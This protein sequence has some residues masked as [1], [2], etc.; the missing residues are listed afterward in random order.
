MH[1][2]RL[3][4]RVLVLE[5]VPDL[6]VDCRRCL[7]V[8]RDVYPDWAWSSTCSYMHGFL[9]DV[10]HHVR[11]HDEL[12]KLGHGAHGADDVVLL[13]P[14]VPDVHVAALVNPLGSVV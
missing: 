7:H 6:S 11:R 3:A 12:G 2:R 1:G 13:R 10:R 8:C 5:E 4:K 14:V 9:D